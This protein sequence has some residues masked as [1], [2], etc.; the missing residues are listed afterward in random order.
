MKVHPFNMSTKA[1]ATLPSSKISKILN[2]PN[3]K[4]YQSYMIIFEISKQ[5]KSPNKSNISN[6]KD[7]KEVYNI[8][9]IVGTLCSTSP[10]MRMQL[11]H[12]SKIC[13]PPPRSYHRWIISHSIIC[14]IRKY[15]LYDH[16]VV[17]LHLYEFDCSVV[18]LHLVPDV[19]GGFLRLHLHD[20]CCNGKKY[21]IL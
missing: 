11:S 9:N 3:I 17:R 14:Y 6:I 5:S 20:A 18:R 15:H 16:P 1:T 10:C 8:P 12:L 7:M 13:S 4:K 2:Y 21:K 19:C